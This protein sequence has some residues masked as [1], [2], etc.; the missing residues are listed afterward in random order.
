[1]KKIVASILHIIS[2]L[3]I[4][5][6]ILNVVLIFTIGSIFGYP[7]QDSATMFGVDFHELEIFYIILA[8]ITYIIGK[9]LKQIK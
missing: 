6:S 7:S 5:A 3:A 4:V 9:Q 8:I 2:L 1:M